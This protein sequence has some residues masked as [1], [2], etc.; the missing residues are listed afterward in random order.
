M[1]L[2]R[3]LPTEG[4]GLLPAFPGSQ[5]QEGGFVK[6]AC[7][8]FFL[9]ILFWLL[10][11]HAGAFVPAPSLFMDLMLG[12]MGTTG[13]TAMDVRRNLVSLEGE[14]TPVEEKFL[15]NI[16]EVFRSESRDGRSFRIATA[17]DVFLAVQGGE[18]LPAPKP[19]LEDYFYAPLLI[20]E[21]GALLH[22]LQRRGVD[23]A[24]TGLDRRGGT[25]CY[26]LGNAGGSHLLVDKESFFPLFLILEEQASGFRHRVVFQYRD[27]QKEEGSA[28]F[29]REI[30]IFDGD[31]ALLQEI[32]ILQ[33]TGSSFPDALTD[34]G[35][36]KKR[37]PISEEEA[38]VVATDSGD[39][40]S[41]DG[42]MEDLDKRLERFKKRFE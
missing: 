18:R 25:I 20:R 17:S 1:I 37:H 14:T 6:K 15:F 40:D 38:P 41:L 5:T 28:A 27:W 42:A 31:G 24:R 10:P 4:P 23:I 34:L 13:K 39:T 12:S 11:F 35:E 30:T 3:D 36:Q 19:R 21:K 26:R 33:M 29:P 16:P 32:R 8:G 9:W 22:F 2:W 7:K